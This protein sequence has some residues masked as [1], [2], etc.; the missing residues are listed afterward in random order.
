ME[1]DLKNNLC[2]V[3]MTGAWCN[4]EFPVKHQNWRSRRGTQGKFNMKIYDERGT[5]VGE[6][7]RPEPVEQDRVWWEAVEYRCHKLG[8]YYWNG[9]GVTKVIYPHHWSSW[10][11][12]PIPR[13]TPEQLKAVGMRER[14]LS[15]V[16]PQKGYKIWNGREV[17]TWNTDMDIG[18]RR[19]VLV[20]AEKS[21]CTDCTTPAILCPQANEPKDKV[22]ECGSKNAKMSAEKEVRCPSCA[23]ARDCGHFSYPENDDCFVSVE[24]EPA[25]TS[26]VGCASGMIDGAPQECMTCFPWHDSTAERKNYTLAPAPAPKMILD[27]PACLALMIATLDRAINQSPYEKEK[28]ALIDAM[29]SLQVAAKVSAEVVQFEFQEGEPLASGVPPDDWLKPPR[30]CLTSAPA[31]SNTPATWLTPLT[32]PAPLVTRSRRRPRRIGRAQANMRS[33]AGLP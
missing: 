21:I 23:D 19:W 28:D 29:E 8:E 15:P 1:V 9:K 6:L 22:K 11:M 30:V 24:K 10:I 26:C 17:I 32:T 5:Q 18:K 33:P 13:A 16:M 25:H 2:I 12:R 14:D 4:L 20:P 31:S 3:K 27:I 7:E